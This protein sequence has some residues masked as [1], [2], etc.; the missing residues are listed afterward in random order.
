MHESA[1]F[2]NS[3]NLFGRKNYLFFVNQGALVSQVKTIPAL[4]YFSDPLV[5]S[6]S[7]D[8]AKDRCFK[9]KGD[10][11]AKEVATW[12]F[13]SIL[14]TRVRSSATPCLF[15]EVTQHSCPLAFVKP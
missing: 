9:L 11:H 10:Q 12:F 3:S 5:E 15:I 14:Q 4:S 1:G 2:T 13:E 6:L 7:F 8:V